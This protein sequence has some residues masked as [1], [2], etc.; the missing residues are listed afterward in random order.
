MVGSIGLGTNLGIQVILD[1]L[2][3]HLILAQLGIIFIG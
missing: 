3:M 1:V 2:V